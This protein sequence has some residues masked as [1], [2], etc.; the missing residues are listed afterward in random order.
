MTRR[1]EEIPKGWAAIIEESERRAA[2]IERLRAALEKYA[3]DDY[4]GYNGN[5]DYARRVLTN[6][7]NGDGK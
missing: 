5:G 7:Q 1:T 3:E 6:E 2:E 4:N